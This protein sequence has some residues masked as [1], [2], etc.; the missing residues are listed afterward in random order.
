LTLIFAGDLLLPVLW[1]SLPPSIL[2]TSPTPYLL[3][4]VGHAL[5]TRTA[6]NRIVP[7]E[8]G[9]KWELLAAVPDGLVRAL[10]LAWTGAAAVVD[11]SV[12]LCQT[13]AIVICTF[14]VDNLVKHESLESN[15]FALVVL[16]WIA[17]YGGALVVNAASM[18]RRE[19]AL[20]TPPEFRPGGWMTTDFWVCVLHQGWSRDFMHQH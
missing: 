4:T 6:V 2:L 16:T 11:S 20:T 19:W 1:P 17:V 13:R 3:F 12:P 8:A 9:L 7:K 18:W 5:F 15:W 14:L 10:N